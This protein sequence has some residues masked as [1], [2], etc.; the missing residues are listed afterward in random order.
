PLLY[1]E[2]KSRRLFRRGA[3]LLQSRKYFF[4]D[5]GDLV[6]RFLVRHVSRVAHHEEMAEAADVVDEFRELAGDVV[7]RSDEHD[8]RLDEVLDRAVVRVDGL[9]LARGRRAL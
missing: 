7:G 5:Q 8:S 3:R 2:G 4:C 9:A 6:D 1:K